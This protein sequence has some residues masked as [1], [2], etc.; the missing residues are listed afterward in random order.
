MTIGALA[1]AAVSL[2]AATDG[3]QSSAP[4]MVVIVRHAEAVPDAGR[5]PVLGDAGRARAAALAEALRD[6]GV[7]A[8]YATQYQRTRLTGADV[9]AAANIEVT[10]RAIEGS[11]DEYAAAL[12]THVLSSHAGRTVVIVGHS[13]TV[14]ALVKAFSGL[15]MADLAHDSYDTMF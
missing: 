13:N 12:A 3:A 4:T 1:L 5:D 6:A 14:P 10:V 11:A 15:V 2:L 7:A 9:A 8:V